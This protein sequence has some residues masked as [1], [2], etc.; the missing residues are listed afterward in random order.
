MSYSYTLNPKSSNGEVLNI[1]C[2]CAGQWEH[3]VAALELSRNGYTCRQNTE[4]KK[5][6]VYPKDALRTRLNVGGCSSVYSFCLTRSLAYSSDFWFFIT[7][8]IIKSK[9]FCWIL[10]VTLTV[11]FILQLLQHS[12]CWACWCHFAF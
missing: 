9:F 8:M 4:N 3:W 12:I 5:I 2:V 1:K 6:C 10:L 7:D 11:V